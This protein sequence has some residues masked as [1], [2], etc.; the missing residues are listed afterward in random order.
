MKRKNIRIIIAVLLLAITSLAAFGCK[1]EVP[2]DKLETM[3]SYCSEAVN[4]VKITHKVSVYSA[5]NVLS[6][7]EVIYNIAADKSVSG[8]QTV[9]TLNDDV[10]AEELYDVDVSNVAYTAEEATG[11]LPTSIRLNSDDFNGDYE[12]VVDNNG[13]TT[14]SFAVKSDSVKAYFGVSDAEAAKISNVRVSVV[15]ANGRVT[16]YKATYTTAN[17][18][19]AEILITFDYAA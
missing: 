11:A 10:T 7:K 3:I 15:A 9:K 14:L 12:N 5:D 2:A 6:S 4:A 8:T 18:N 19:T 1:P 17:D 16:E 13:V